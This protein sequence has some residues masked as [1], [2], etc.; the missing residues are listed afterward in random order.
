[1]R[2]CFVDLFPVD[3]DADTP[4][5][6]PLGGMQ[7]SAGYLAAALAE[8][9]HDVTLLT[10]TS[11]P[12]R[13]RGVA[14]HSL[15]ADAAGLHGRRIDAVISLTADPQ[16]VRV[17]FD[18]DLPVLL[19][20][21]HADDQPAVECL[22]QPE[23]RDGWDGFVLVSDWQRA[24][25]VDRFGIDPAR[26][27]VLRNAIGPAFE[28]LFRDAADLATAKQQADLPLLAYTSTP[29]RG[30]ELLVKLFPLLDQPARLRVFSSMTPYAT[31]G[32]DE[33][34][35]ELYQTCRNTP[36]IDYVGALAQPELA[37][38]LR[39]A[40]VLAYPNI[41]A[42]TG[43]IAVM[44]AMAAGCSVVTSDLGA[45]AETTEGFAALV[46]VGENWYGYAQRYL[47]VLSA[48]MRHARSPAGLDL[49]WQQVRHINATATWTVRA[50]QW[51]EW[52]STR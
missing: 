23:R 20:T 15:A 38:A 29:F 52:L 6:R 9:G 44:E 34:F 37:T 5:E 27:V 24:R 2:L 26:S 17:L 36:G 50:V 12:G 19:W 18:R 25:F 11:R 41:F 32:R 22:A 46:E 21:G 30:L 51:T 43:C 47:T 48:V 3:Y 8:H 39:S 10:H 31:P 33:T 14:C 49:Q 35:C 40:H 7:S 16:A 45:L 28:N 1:M 13:R 42:E 4:Y